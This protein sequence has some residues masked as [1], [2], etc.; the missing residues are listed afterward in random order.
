MNLAELKLA[1]KENSESVVRFRLPDGSLS[2]RHAHI[3]EV[4]LVTKSFIDCGGTTRNEARC[5]LQ[6]W[7]ADDIDHRLPAGKLLSIIERANHLLRG[8]EGLAVELEHDIGFVSQFQLVGA[9][10]IA[11]ELVINLAGRHTACLAP[12]KCCPPS[13]QSPQVVSLGRRG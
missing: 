6:S 9:E 10:L 8:Q 7:V 12:E 5:Q 13:G 1:L 2:A 3:T 11:G 4:G